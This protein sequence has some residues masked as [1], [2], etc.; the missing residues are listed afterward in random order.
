TAG[1]GAPAGRQAV[2]PEKKVIARIDV[3]ALNRG[4]VEGEDLGWLCWHCHDLK[5]RHDLKFAGPPGNRW[6]VDRETGEPWRG[7]SGTGPPD[8]QR[9]RRGP[10]DPDPPRTSPPP[11]EQGGLFTLAD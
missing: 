4:R 11:P 5:T 7:P 6:L 2:R 1:P 3:E 10:T 9:A 8:D